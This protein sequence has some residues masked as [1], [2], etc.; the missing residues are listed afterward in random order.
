M[1]LLIILDCR[2]KI[3]GTQIHA[4]ALCKELKKK[5]KKYLLIYKKKNNFLKIAKKKKLIFII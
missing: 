5:K 4:L 2:G 1:S 3:E